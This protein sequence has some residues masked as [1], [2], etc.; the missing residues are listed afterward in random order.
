MKWKIILKVFITYKNYL[1]YLFL[2]LSS[3]LA[4]SPIVVCDFVG[5]DDSIQLTDNHHVLSG[6]TWDNLQWA[7]SPESN[8][9]PLTWVTYTI[10]HT[11]FGLNPCVF[12]IINLILHI[13]S[14]MLLFLLLKRM[15]GKFWESALVGVLFAVHPINVESVAWIAE[16]NNV[17]SGLLFMLTL[18]IYNSY[19]EHTTWKRYI[20]TLV[21]FELGLLAKPS[22]IT[23]PFILLLIDLWPLERIKVAKIKE[24]G[25][26]WRL[27]F[28]G[29]PLPRLILEKIP[30]L[31]LT[32]ISLASNLISSNKRMILYSAEQVQIGLRISNA[33]VSYVKYLGKLFWPHDLIFPY[34]YPKMIP[35]WEVAGAI[36]ILVL[37]TVTA[38]RTVFRNPYYLVGWLWFLG[39]LVPFLGI[40]QAGMWPEMADRYAYLSFIGIFI[41]LSW[42]I[43]SMIRRLKYYH[44][45]LTI[46]GSV[47]IIVLMAITWRQVGFW[48]DSETLCN[49]ILKVNWNIS[50]MHDQLGI[51]LI[52]KGD[53]K[54]GIRHYQ[55]AIKIDPFNARAYSNLGKILFFL[56][57]SKGGIANIMKALEINPYDPNDN[58]LAARFFVRMGKT[59]LAAKHFYQALKTDPDNTEVHKNLANLLL[60]EGN[61]DGAIIHYTKVLQINP[62]QADVYNNLGTAFFKKENIKKAC[63]YYQE[64]LRERPNYTLAFNNLNIAKM[65]QKNLED[66]LSEIL[67]LV[68]LD[69]QNPKLYLRLGDTYRL[70]GKYDEA[71]AQYHK[72]ISTQPKLMEAWYG[73]V[74]VYSNQQDYTK[75]LEVLQN[76]RLL[77]PNNP[78]IYYNIACIYGKLNNLDES[79][80]W[81]KQAIEKG[82]HNWDLIKKD[83]D[84]ASI[85]NTSFVNELIK[86]H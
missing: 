46:G 16:L 61:Y 14:S 7:F 66:Q 31:I 49:H 21:V 25:K 69:P 10:G 30:F 43:P 60:Q 20:L 6:L 80:I 65:N 63:E 74:I 67:E 85:R 55:E 73:L 78:Q 71:T 24:N 33:L 41:I 35:L 50:Q 58:S 42:G 51:A 81:L 54:G 76:M 5:Y 52:M 45:L 77:Q 86:N 68:K 8:C 4:Y 3:A 62:H 84:L 40:I 1:I 47:I 72:A 38:L 59:D 22:L 17:L 79:I 9:S 39:S 11:L 32:I 70:L 18:L 12:H 56:K 83:P 29:I 27:K 23:L 75:A 28:S 34:L 26:I 36:F 82:F 48:K 2:I 44:R 37:I 19:T 57:D 13:T 53:V 64:S 15:S